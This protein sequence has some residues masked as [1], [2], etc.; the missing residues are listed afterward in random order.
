MSDM[1]LFVWCDPYSVSYGSA[2]VFAVAS[3]VDEARKI[4]ASGE[5]Y[6]FGKYS[7]GTPPSL[8]LGEPTRVVD[9]PCAEWHTWQE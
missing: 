4:A 8:V 6:S 1:K 3:D 9:L 5:C 7:D 2:M